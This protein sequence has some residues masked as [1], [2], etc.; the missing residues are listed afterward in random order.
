MIRDQQGQTDEAS[1]PGGA[2]RGRMTS[3]GSTAI[4]PLGVAAPRLRVGALRA[5]LPTAAV[6]LL[7]VVPYL[8]GLGGEFV[9]DDVRLIRNNPQVPR[10]AALAV[11]VTPYEP[12]ALYRPLTMLT[13]IANARLDRGP[14]GFHAVNIALHLG[15]SLMVLALARRLGFAPWAA[16]A[17]AA[18]FAAHPI[19]SEAVTGIVGRAELLAAAGALATLLTFAGALAARDGRRATWLTSSLALFAAGLL[20]KE[21]AFTVIALIGVVHWRLVPSASPARRL[22]AMAPYAAVGLAYLG[23]RLAVVGSLGLPM[24]PGSLDNPLAHVDAATRWRTALVILWDY[25]ALLTAPLRLSADYSYAQVPLALGWS[26]ARALAALGLLGGLAAGALLAIRRCPELAVAAAF[27]AVPLALTA[28][29]AF[30]I[31][32]I[33]AERLLYLPSVGWCLAAGWLLGRLAMQRARLAGALLATVLLLFAARTAVRNADWRDELTLYAATVA[34]APASAKAQYN[35]AVALERAGDLDAALAHHRRALELYPA[36]AAAAFGI[37]R[38]EA[39]RGNETAALAAYQ[40]ALARD[41][42]FAKAHLQIGLWYQQ[43]GQAAAAEAAYRAGLEA[44]PDNPLLLV[45]LAA[46]RLAQGD[47]WGARGALARLDAVPAP[48][49]PTTVALIAQARHEIEVGMR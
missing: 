24:P 28:N 44:E 46:V 8:N 3:H 40:D 49:D 32:T 26:D 21:S 38:A 1:Q 37:G 7:A 14:R 42:R 9:F 10:H 31:G 33:K 19:H 45:N 6:A 16:F 34:V 41:W 39:L 22:A 48:L 13:Y 29:L 12:G 4:G 23:L 5:L 15:V 25:L 43:R 20:A 18:L 2:G 27:F 17:A 36:Y 30:P 11:F 35:Y 47:R